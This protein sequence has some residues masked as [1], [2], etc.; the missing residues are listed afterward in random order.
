[1][2]R[3]WWLVPALLV[4]VLI[5]G[6]LS[7]ER[8]TVITVTS[9][10]Y[11]EVPQDA[12]GNFDIYTPS[13]LI[14]NPSNMTFD[15]VDVDITIAPAASYCHGLT[16]TFTFPVLSPSEKK[17]VQ[18]SIAEFGDLGCQYNYSYQVFVRH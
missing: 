3:S 13:F 18:F 8:N 5:C 1:M 2:I 10:D 11:G 14:T 7:E 17:T 6:C 15:N 16:K 9:L 12:V 4:L